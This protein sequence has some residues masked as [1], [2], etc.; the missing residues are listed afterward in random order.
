MCKTLRVIFD[1]FLSTQ[2][3]PHE[4]FVV[5]IILHVDARV[6]VFDGLWQVDIGAGF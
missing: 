3:R 6:F 4:A 2:Y 5:A 1:V